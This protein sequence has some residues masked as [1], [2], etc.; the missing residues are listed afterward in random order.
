MTVL[1]KMEALECKEYYLNLFCVANS[2]R[3]IY[4][5]KLPERKSNFQTSLIIVPVAERVKVNFV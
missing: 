2:A 4:K 5:G 3:V 1:V